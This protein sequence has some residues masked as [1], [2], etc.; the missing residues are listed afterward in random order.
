MWTI[1]ISKSADKCLKK[2]PLEIRNVFDAWK[3]IAQFS[4]PSGLKKINGYRDHA[5]NGEWAGARSSSLNSQWRVIYYVA[6]KEIKI[7]VLEITP[8]DYRRK[9]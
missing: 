1:Q 4:G 9:L 3:N 8:H 2:A 6:E 7:F 5:L